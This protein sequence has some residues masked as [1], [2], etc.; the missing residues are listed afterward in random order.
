[1]PSAANAISDEAIEWIVRLNSGDATA[2]DAQAFRAW[3]GRDIEHEMAALEAE[4]IWHGV[5]AVGQPLRDAEARRRRN[6]NRRTALGLGAVTLTGAALY[7]S[8]T[9]R[10][11]TSDY[12]TGVGERREVALADGSVI[13]LNALSAVSVDFTEHT[14]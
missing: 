12:V 5:A 10:G 13:R 14:R 4:T 8:G 11:L 3:R 9:F 6:V 1:M 7:A 2:A